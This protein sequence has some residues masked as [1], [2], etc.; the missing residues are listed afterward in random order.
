M[1][2]FPD[3]KRI[4]PKNPPLKAIVNIKDVKLVR[5]LNKKDNGYIFFD[6]DF[7]T[8]TKKFNIKYIELLFKVFGTT[9]L[10]FY[11]DDKEY[12]TTGISTN[13]ESWD[14][15]NNYSAVLS[16]IRVSDLH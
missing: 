11:T 4:Y 16:C 10:A 2:F 14:C 13:L 5:K 6:I 9:E 8:H 3:F 1:Q 15:E 12:S 7:G